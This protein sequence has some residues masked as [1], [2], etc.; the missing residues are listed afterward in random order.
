[1]R[2]LRRSNQ[3]GNTIVEFTLVAVFLVPLLLGTVN[4]GMNL[5]RSIQVTQL[6]RD[7]GH[8]FARFV[9]FSEAGN[10]DILVR[11]SEGLGM[12]RTGGN[13][14]VTLT[15]MA[16]IGDLECEAGGYEPAN[17]PNHGYSVITQQI[18]IGNNQLRPSNFGDPPSDLL[19][20]KGEIDPD[21]YLTDIRT[22]ADGF[23]SLLS[24]QAGE[25]AYV[26]EAYVV[27]PE[28][29]FPGMFDDTE[30][31]ARTIF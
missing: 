21:V 6:S 23:S 30:V 18:V 4:V 1:M 25:I 26:A 9:D 28:F 17:C 13:G 19:D 12:T 14:R 24:L 11:L 20:S 31:Y 16:Q 29:D 7:A 22:R 3:R 15:R 5:S 2:R 10:Q 8:M 27:S